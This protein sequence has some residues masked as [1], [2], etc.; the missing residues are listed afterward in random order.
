MFCLSNALMHVDKSKEKDLF[1][2]Y[3]TRYLLMRKCDVIS[4]SKLTSIKYTSWWSRQIL[5]SHVDFLLG[6][7]LHFWSKYTKIDWEQCHKMSGKNLLGLRKELK[8]IRFDKQIG[9]DG[10][11]TIVVIL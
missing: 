6:I 2:N 9:S 7:F 5:L 10:R 4:Q 11:K 8:R 3:C 1:V